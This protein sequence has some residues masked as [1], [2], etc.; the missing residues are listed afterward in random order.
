MSLRATATEIVRRVQA[1]GFAAY[2]VGG[3]VRDQL[4]G[5]EPHDFDITTDARPDDI[6]KIFPRT[7]PVGR[8]F[9]VMAVDSESRVVEFAEKPTDPKPTPDDPESCLAS[10]GIYIFSARYLTNV[11]A[12]THRRQAADT[13]SVPTSFRKQLSAVAYSH[14]HFSMKIENA[15]RIGATLVRSTHIGKPTSISLP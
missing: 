3:C 11:S 5:H 2:F 15:K 13:I 14:F 1:A 9:G 4:L 8:Q 12:K 6:E 10:M 7:I